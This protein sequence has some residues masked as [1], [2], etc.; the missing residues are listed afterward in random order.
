M[1]DLW[2]NSLLLNDRL[3]G[4]EKVKK[5][6]RSLI[7]GQAARLSHLVNV[8]MNMLS[9][10]HRGCGMGLMCGPLNASIFKLQTLLL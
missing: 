2:L 10:N 6:I 1:D 5:K 8:V 7:T 9:C 4:L 3:N